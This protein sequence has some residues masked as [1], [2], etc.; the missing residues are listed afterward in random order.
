MKINTVDI[1]WIERLGK[2]ILQSVIFSNEICDKT[3]LF[4]RLTGEVYTETD[5]LKLK[6]GAS[7]STD[8]YMNLLDSRFWMRYTDISNCM[9][10]V[11]YKGRGKI[12]IGTFN[13]TGHHI[14]ESHKL[15][16]DIPVDVSF[17]LEFKK[18]TGNIFFRCEA[19]RELTIHCAEYSAES[20]CHNDTRL[21]IVFCTYHRHQDIKRNADTILKSRFF[22]KNSDLYGKAEVVIVDNG[23]D[24]VM[25]KSEHTEL[26]YNANTGGA[27]GFCRGIS[28]ITKPEKNVTDVLLMDDDVIFDAEALYRL[29]AFLTFRKA[30]YRDSVTAGRMFRKDKPWV[31]YTACEIWNSGNIKHIGYNND[32]AL[33]ENILDVNRGSGEYSGWWMCCFSAEYLSKNFPLPFF[34]HCDDVELGLRHGGTPIILNGVQVWH[35][36]YEYR[37][38]ALITYYDMRNTLFVNEIMDLLRPEKELSIWKEKISKA[39]LD[40]DYNL[41]YM[42]IRAMYD[43]L[44]G[45]K[46]LCGIRPDKYHKKISRRKFFV[47][48]R[49]ALM[50]RLTSHKYKKRFEKYLCDNA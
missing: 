24:M 26:V 36:T 44:K 40:K 1:F 34:L 48:Y 8:T 37:Q 13:E 28:V 47:R 14:L 7:A 41:E 49:N 39:H 35:E 16:S 43:Y 22:D 3:D 25:Q 27:G 50:W 38:N 18:Y 33:Y 46:W 5:I 20:I 17:D 31:Q 30:L 21:G 19:D 12:E 29:Y 32:M 10:N 2:V 9:L 6:N 45:L 15:Q 42:M 23:R 11:R 4:V